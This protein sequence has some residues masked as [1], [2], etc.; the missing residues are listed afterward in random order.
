MNKTERYLLHIIM[1][2]KNEYKITFPSM[3]DANH[4]ML[5]REYFFKHANYTVYDL[6]VVNYY[7]SMV[8]ERVA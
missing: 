8:Q 5:E 7:S 6:D 1:G 3:E 2:N 4:Y